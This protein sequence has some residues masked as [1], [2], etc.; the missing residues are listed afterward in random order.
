VFITSPAVTFIALELSGFNAHF[1]V[2]QEL[3]FNNVALDNATAS[4]LAHV[5]GFC[6]LQSLRD[7]YSLV[8]QQQLE[9]EFQ[10]TIF[11]D[12]RIAARLERRK[13]V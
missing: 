2:S 9:K 6:L 7:K 8:L 4:V 11:V 5:L 13:T 12:A 1:P 3:A 10:H